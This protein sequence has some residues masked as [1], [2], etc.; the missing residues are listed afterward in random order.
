MKPFLPVLSAAAALFLAS[1]GMSPAEQEEYVER[2]V[3]VHVSHLTAVADS[4]KL[5]WVRATASEGVELKML[6]VRLFADANG[7]GQMQ[8]GEYTG[9]ARVAEA[10]GSG[11][12]LLKIGT[13]T[14]QQEL[15]RPTLLVEV[16][17]TDGLHTQ[18]IALN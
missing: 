14:F 4:S 8:D 16:H 6:R 13:F 17:T 9:I 18:V 11:A 15:V 2:R 10:E 5:P 3:T 12:K 1:C 7:D